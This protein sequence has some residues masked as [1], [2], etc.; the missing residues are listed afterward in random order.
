[1]ILYSLREKA[2][3]RGGWGGGWGGGGGDSLTKKGVVLPISQ[4]NRYVRSMGRKNQYFLGLISWEGGGRISRELILGTGGFFERKS[5][6]LGAI[7]LGEGEKKSA[8]KRSEGEI[9]RNYCWWGCLFVLASGS[10][11]GG[12][13]RKLKKK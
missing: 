8:L 13:K 12:K 11:S 9:L 10:S 1:M 3:T 5:L 4:E 7:L 6:F 2:I